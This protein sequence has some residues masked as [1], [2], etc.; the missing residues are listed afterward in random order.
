MTI[1]DSNAVIAM[2]AT[3]AT[4][5]SVACIAINA[6][7]AV[8]AV[9]AVDATRAVLAVVTIYVGILQVSRVSINAYGSAQ[10]F[11]Q[12]GGR[13]KRGSLLNRRVCM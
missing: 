4:S 11:A 3:D 2:C 9:V 1:D 10:V 6:P 5:T 8:V 13:S 7:S 12:A